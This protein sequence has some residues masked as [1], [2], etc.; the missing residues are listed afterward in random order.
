MAA[1]STLLKEPTVPSIGRTAGVSQGPIVQS[2]AAQVISAVGDVAEIAFKAFKSQKLAEAKQLEKDQTRSGQTA[3]IDLI[4]QRTQGL[5]SE[6]TFIAKR[7]QARISVF[8]SYGEV[9]ME[10][11]DKL[12]EAKQEIA[13]QTRGDNA[14]EAGILL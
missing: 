5:I 4:E 3:G 8:R 11:F 1:F 10:A 9:G 14:F 7:N 6:S 2:P 13:V 12:F